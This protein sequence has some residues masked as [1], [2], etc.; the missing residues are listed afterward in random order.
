M[1]LRTSS[2]G[3]LPC[4]MRRA[5]YYVRALQIFVPVPGRRLPRAKKCSGVF[6][7][8]VSLDFYQRKRLK[9]TVIDSEPNTHRAG[10]PYP[11]AQVSADSANGEDPD[12][13]LPP[14]P[15]STRLDLVEPDLAQQRSY[16]HFQRPVDDRRCRRHVAHP[17]RSS[18]NGRTSW[19]QVPGQLRSGRSPKSE[20]ALTLSVRLCGQN[21][22]C[23]ANGHKGPLVFLPVAYLKCLVPVCP[24]VMLNR[25]T[26][27]IPHSGQ[28]D[29]LHRKT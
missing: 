22:H 16:S 1:E 9:E 2:A 17:S 10:R 29:L 20:A 6:G 24:G 11:V 28:R 15:G 27:K 5:S 3:S 13:I 26:G 4:P 7:K 23:C 18:I 14:M 19:R 21:A 8:A 25:V 12:Q